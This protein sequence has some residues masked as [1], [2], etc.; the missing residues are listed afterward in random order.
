MN[1]QVEQDRVEVKLSA[2]GLGLLQ[3]RL[4]K[5]NRRARRLGVPPVTVKQVTP[6]V[7]EEKTPEFGSPYFVDYADFEVSVT[8]PRLNGFT[9]LAT[10][11]HTDAGNLIKTT[12]NLPEGTDLSA[13]RTCKP[14]CDHCNKTRNRADTYVVEGNGKRMQVGSNC[15]ADVLGLG[16]TPAQAAE[17]AAWIQNVE[18]TLGGSED[19]WDR[20]G[21]Y[22]FR[23]DEIPL[24]AFL[25]TVSALV[26]VDGYRSRKYVEASGGRSTTT[27]SDAWFH[28]DPPRGLTRRDRD[29]LAKKY[30]SFPICPTED[31]RKEAEEAIA[32]AAAV[33]PRSD[34]D[35]NLKTVSSSEMLNVW[36][37]GIAA[38]IV[39]AYRRHLEKEVERKAKQAGLPSSEHVGEIGKRIKNT[40][41]KY[42]ATPFAGE[43]D[44]GNFFIHRF[45]DEH[46]NE[47]VWKTS[48]SMESEQPGTEFTAAFTPK[49]HGEFNGRKQTTVS[50]VKLT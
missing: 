19:D 5:L 20:E 17:W 37:G 26:R 24:V 14:N 15:L 40:K 10:L 29:E 43:N 50:R 25:A 8:I 23:C 30:G 32:W 21:G 45:T 38:Y 6:W 12:P 4:E 1:E 7:P 33:E 18:M 36:N 34:F 9:F 39:A 16:I 22:S 49:S 46:G 31:D 11:E 48:T 41:I 47:L 42:I 13:Y 44:F 2:R 28:L 27:A 35:W 3:G